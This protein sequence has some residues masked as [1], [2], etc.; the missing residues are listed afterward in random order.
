MVLDGRGSGRA[1]FVFAFLEALSL[2]Q[3]FS[4]RR[5]FYR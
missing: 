2:S 4:S 3:K 1:G 5:N